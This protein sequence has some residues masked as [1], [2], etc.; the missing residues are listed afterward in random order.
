MIGSVSTITIYLH[1]NLCHYYAMK[2][3]INI[4]HNIHI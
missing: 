2:V 4:Y 3:D 1:E